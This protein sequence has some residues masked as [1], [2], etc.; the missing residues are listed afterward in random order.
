MSEEG[1]E[2]I[3]QMKLHHLP[4]DAKLILQRQRG[5]MITS[6]KVQFGLPTTFINPDNKQTVWNRGPSIQLEQLPELIKILTDAHK[7][8]S[9]E[10]TENR[11]VTFADAIDGYNFRTD[12]TSS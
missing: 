10:N 3:S 6:D 7:K 12:E 9:K 2:T 4:N 8:Y 5:D 11:V 1:F